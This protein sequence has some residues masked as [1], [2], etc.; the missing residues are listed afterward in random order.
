VTKLIIG[1]GYLGRR[2]ANSW[3]KRG[4]RVVGTTRLAPHAGDLRRRGIE[5]VVCDVLDRDSLRTLPR[6]D[7]LLFCVGFDRSSGA[8]MREVHV[9]GLAN[10]LDVVPRPERFIYISSTGVYGQTQGEE[11][12]ESAATEPVEESGVIMLEAEKLLRPQ[13][14]T[15][16]VLRFAGIYGPGR[17]LRRQAL[18]AGIPIVGDPEKWL[19][20]I[21][22][23]DGANAVL[24]AEA[25]GNPAEPIYNIC[26]DRP[27][28]RRDFYA[29]L[30]RLLNAQAPRFV[31]PAPGEAPPHE[32]ANRR[33]RAERL[34]RDLAVT[35]AFPSFEEGLPASLT[36][37]P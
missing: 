24:A 28:R 7:T 16:F 31:A 33:I 13:V 22:V 32:Q 3:C 12:D 36:P 34:H 5:P 35:L 18:L 9:D 2:V 1:C 17:L 30:A 15:A 37:E 4:E 19:N 25:R 11:V 29:S 20:L 8:S 6:A 14:P 23:E 26:D 27:V 10:V 21:H